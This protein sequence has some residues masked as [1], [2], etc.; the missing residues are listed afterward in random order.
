MVFVD[1]VLDKSLFLINVKSHAPMV[2]FVKTMVVVPVPL[3][4]I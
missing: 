2:K 1:A 4:N 3:V